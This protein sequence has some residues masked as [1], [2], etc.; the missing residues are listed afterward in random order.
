MG[1]ESPKSG[2]AK[3]KATNYRPH[4][5]S[6]PTHGALEADGCCERR[7][8]L[9]FISMATGKLPVFWYLAGSTNWSQWVIFERKRT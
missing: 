8:S 3:S 6:S 9:F 7:D 5:A 1:G 4:E 2:R